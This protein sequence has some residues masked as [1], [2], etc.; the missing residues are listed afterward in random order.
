[1]YGRRFKHDQV[2]YVFESVQKLSHCLKLSGGIDS[3]MS[4]LTDSFLLTQTWYSGTEGKFGC[5]PS[6]ITVGHRA[7]HRRHRTGTRSL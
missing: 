5:H 1:V 7:S 6:S 2:R 3:V 4:W